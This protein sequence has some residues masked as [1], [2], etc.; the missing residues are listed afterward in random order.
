MAFFIRDFEGHGEGRC[1]SAL[2]IDEASASGRNADAAIQPQ[3]GEFWEAVGGRGIGIY[4]S[5]KQFEGERLAV[6]FGSP[7]PKGTGN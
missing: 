1:R 5:R 3:A 4:S 6:P 7:A 2:P